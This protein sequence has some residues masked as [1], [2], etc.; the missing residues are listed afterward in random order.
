MLG[1]NLLWV[2]CAVSTAPFG[3]AQT[4]TIDTVA[5][6]GRPGSSGTSYSAAGASA[7]ALDASGNLYVAASGLNQIWV[8]SPSAAVTEVIGK[9]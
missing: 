5:G 7:V 2:V 1:K 6:G 4:L 8:V 3:A 9:D